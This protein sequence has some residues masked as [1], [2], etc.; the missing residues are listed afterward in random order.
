METS[1]VRLPLWGGMSSACKKHPETCGSL[2]ACDLKQ[3]CHERYIRNCKHSRR[4]NP[5]SLF[6]LLPDAHAG[7]QAHC[8]QA[9]F[10]HS[11]VSPTALLKI[12]VPDTELRFHYLSSL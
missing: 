10:D 4:S 12:F 3:L 6:V 7:E 9:E 5:D 1:E 2:L 8:E 11:Q